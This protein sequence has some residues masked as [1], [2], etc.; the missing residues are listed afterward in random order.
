VFFFFKQKT[1]YEIHASDWSSDVCSS[2]LLVRWNSPTRGQV[3]PADF[4][5]LAE[6]TG[7]IVP[8]GEWVLRTACAEAAAW[9]NHVGVAANLSPVQVKIKRLMMVV[10]ETL[11]ATGLP[12]R[13]L[14]LEI[15]ES[16]LLQDTV[17]V[18]ALRRSLHDLGVRISMDDFGTGYSSLNYLL[19]FPF[20]KIKIDRSFTSELR[21]KPGDAGGTTATSEALL[22]SA[23]NAA[24]IVRTIV[25]LGNNLRIATIAEGVETAEQF[26]QIRRMGCTEVQGYFLSRPRPAAE[27]EALRQRLDATMPL[28]AAAPRASP[29]LVA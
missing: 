29:Q 24:I 20:D 11:E 9:P 25:G 16:V 17:V 3:S 13:R 8:I 15:T 18:M 28:I 7:L 4:I 22:A 27:I 10:R 21:G 6:Q 12:A 2:D 26:A 19:R 1:A 14:E 23:R 5:P